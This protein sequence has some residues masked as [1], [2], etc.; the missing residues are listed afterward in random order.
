MIPSYVVA[1]NLSLGDGIGLV[2]KG[3]LGLG[4]ERGGLLWEGSSAWQW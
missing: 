3:S 2:L 1:M 4:K